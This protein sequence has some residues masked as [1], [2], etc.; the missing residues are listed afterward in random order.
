MTPT[1]RDARWSCRADLPF[2]WLLSI[3]GAALLVA[4]LC[5]GA[6]LIALVLSLLGLR[7][8][9]KRRIQRRSMPD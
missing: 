9:C 6:R 7:I 1:D 8:S 4:G 2:R 3:N 5:S